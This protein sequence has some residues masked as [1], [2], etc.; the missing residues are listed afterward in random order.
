MVRWTHTKDATK[1]VLYELYDYLDDPNEIKNHAME[2]PEKVAELEK[3]LNNHP[4]AKME[5]EKLLSNKKKN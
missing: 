5:P 2:N 4:K 3:L 1:E